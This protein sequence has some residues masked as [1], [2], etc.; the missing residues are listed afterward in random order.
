MREM[1]DSG[2]EW[3]GLIPNNWTTHRIKNNF[4][5]ISGSG[6]APYM[7]GQ[8]Q[9][10]YPV[11]KASDIGT[12]NGQVLTASQNYITKAQSAFFTIVPKGS[13]AFP[14]IGEAMKKNNRTLLGVDACLDNNCQGLVPSGVHERYS[15]YLLSCIDMAWFDN[16]GTVPCL[17]NVKFSNSR[18]PY[19]SLIEQK[20]IAVFLDA[21][22]AEIDALI[23]DIEKQIETLEQYKCSVITEAVTK[24]LNPDVEMKDSGI[25]WAPSIAETF[26]TK[27]LKYLLFDRNEKNNP[28]ITNDILSLTAKQGVVPLAEKE[29][30]GNKPK[31]DLSLYRV[32]RPGDIVMNCM[33][34]IS[35]SVAI[36]NYFGC[37][38]PVYYTFRTIKQEDDERFFN[39][40]FQTVQFQKSLIGFANGILI[41]ESSSGKLNTIRLRI[42]TEA[43][44]SLFV[45]YT[46]PENQKKIAD[47]LDAKCAEIDRLRNEKQNQLDTLAEYKKSLIYEYVT[48]KKEV[49]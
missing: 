45:P 49:S 2:I 26:S 15:L 48:G 42:S 11:C 24:G 47:F 10:D 20:K 14:K 21:K 31:E 23:S 37:L 35:G 30:G 18:F 5:I 4:R 12:C 44:G 17:N 39:Y 6:F 34:V 13:I 27:R 43:L 3:I 8:Q 22:C 33:N 7:Q 38:S 25:E 32:A 9:G 36:S 19:P 28:V 41:K 29:G 46:S 16:A 1:K 40:I